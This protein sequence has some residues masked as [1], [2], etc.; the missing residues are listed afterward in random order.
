LVEQRKAAL[1]LLLINDTPNAELILT[2]KLFEYLAAKRPV[3]C[4]GP[5][6]GDAAEVIRETAAGNTFGFNDEE[7]LKETLRKNFAEFKSQS[8]VVKSTSINKYERK[9]LTVKMGQALNACIVSQQVS[10]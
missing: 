6:N 3:I 1:L 9:N 4:I 8:L 7:G 5:K 10:G 2:G